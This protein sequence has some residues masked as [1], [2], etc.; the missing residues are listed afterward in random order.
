MLV[1]KIICDTQCEIYNEIAH[2]V[3]DV[4]WNFEEFDPPHNSIVIFARQTVNQYHERIKTLA[5]RG[6]FLPVLANPTEGSSTL[7]FQCE[8]LGLLDLVRSGQ[9]LLVGCGEMEPELNCLV[10][11]CYMSRP[12]GYDH[13]TEQC[14]RVDEIYQKIHKPYQFLF[15]NGRTRPHRKYMIE[16]LRFAGV[17]YQ[18]LWTNLDT[19]PV[20]QPIYSE[21]LN[22]PTELKL[23][24]P[25]YE[26]NQFQSGIK[27]HY[28]NSF[29]KHELFNNHWGEIYIR[30]EPYI[31]TYFSLISETVF[32]YPY[33]LRSEKIY[34]PIAMGHP[35]IAIANRGFYRDLRNAG[36][37][38]Y[39]SLIDESF[40][41][42]D[43]NQDRLDRI[44][45]V[46]ADLCHSNLIEFLVACEAISKYNQQHIQELG[47]QIFNEFPTRFFNFI[48]QNS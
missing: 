36:F 14:A 20:Y 31:D 17:L 48:Q 6:V 13:N 33:S 37:Q 4:F 7:K 30:A 47:P 21:F 16:K 5:K 43:H 39:H 25:Q 9:M 12:L 45:Q 15:L 23:L 29:V 46:V 40:D 44:A 1:R 35:F 42:I 32:E 24:P 26:V 2:G 28:T 34:K 19:T 18:A 38:T 41:M 22:T 11:D 10:Y 27:S 8:R 3:D